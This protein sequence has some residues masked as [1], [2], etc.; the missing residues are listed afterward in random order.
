MDTS[1]VVAFSES[2]ALRETLAVLLEHD[3][4]LRC[5]PPAAVE[6][7]DCGAAS[8]A[9]V[10]VRRPDPIVHH[11]RRHWPQVPI[12]AVDVAE[13]PAGQPPAPPHDDSRVYRVPL[14]PHA[15]RSAVLQR[16]AP[17][18]DAALRA[19]ARVIGE[20]LR[21]ELAYAFTALRAFSALHASSAGPDTY[22]LLGTVM[23]EQSHLLSE[24]IDQLERFRSRPRGTELSPEFPAVLCRL[25]Q[26]PDRFSNERGLLCEYTVDAA[27]ADAGPVELAPAVAALLRAHVRRRADSVLVGLRLTRQGVIVRYRRRRTSTT[28]RSWP[29]L[30]AGLALQPWAWSVSTQ[31]I[32]DDQEVVSLRRAA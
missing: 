17:D 14:E 32:D 9:L 22:A 25:L 7:S 20:T 31:I 27:C 5:L 19:T 12:V 13:A 1:V 30:L 16:L 18:H 6:S 29:L 2:P 15:I 21:A 11:L 4:R 8:V 3:C 23:R 24:I 10:A 26:R 28:L